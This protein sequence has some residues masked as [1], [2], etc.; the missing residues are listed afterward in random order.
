[1]ATVVETGLYDFDPY[2]KNVKNRIVNERH[3]LQTP[4]RDDYFFIIPRAAP[5]YVSSLKVYNDTTGALYKEGVDYLPGHYFV[6]AMQS[7]DKP[8]AGSIRFL[9]HSISG[10]VRLEY[11]TLGGQWG[12]NSNAI[13][14]EL[15]NKQLNPL[16]RSWGMI[17]ELPAS[18]PVVDHDQ[19]IDSIVGSE[20]LEEA[21]NSIADVLEAT[22]SGTNASHLQDFNN[23]HKVT[24]TQ[25][26]LSNV[27]NWATAT[28]Q[29]AIQGVANT[30][31]M[32]PYLTKRAIEAIALAPLND[33][34][35][36]TNNPHGVNA[37]DVGLGDVAN[38][39]PAS[40]DEAI[41]P[42]VN[43]RYLTPYT[44]SLLLQAQSGEA[45]YAALQELI[46]GHINNKENPHGVTAA[47]LGAYTRD[48][49]D[50]RL[51]NVSA[52]DTPLFAGMDP[53]QWR[54]TLPSFENLT[55][56]LDEIGAN[57]QNG[58][59]AIAVVDTDDPITQA[60][61][62]AKLDKV[63]ASL[64][65][66]T[67]SYAVV[68]V[69]GNTALIDPYA[70]TPAE[71]PLSGD[72]FAQQNERYY[73]IENDGIVTETANAG[74]IPAEYKPG[75][76]MASADPVTDLYSTA[77]ALYALTTEGSLVRFLNAAATVLYPSGIAGVYVNSEHFNAGE[78]ILIEHE[79]GTMTPYGNSQWVSQ[80]NAILPTITSP[81][82]DVAIGDDHLVLLLDNAS[83]QVYSII[84]SGGISINRIPT[85]A[86]PVTPTKV[87][88]A[89]KHY[90]ILGEDGDCTLHG[91]NDYGQCQLRGFP[92][93]DV[94]CGNGF[95]VVIDQNDHVMF[96]GETETNALLYK[97][98]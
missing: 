30:G 63:P 11:H 48:E 32:N 21:I 34:I 75:G 64:D 44:A 29:H 9:N 13:L 89:F 2:M 4:G 65:A 51:A 74:A 91:N 66:W 85:P 46:T 37:D 88:G 55:T 16:R 57:F 36:N 47:Q 52:Q 40:R 93:K 56:I 49:I 82:A 7:I 83:V 43:N 81:I 90:A 28:E 3:T 62:Q 17:A 86:L 87:H 98:A 38:Y 69:G 59:V 70:D 5:Y 19:S 78:M 26:G 73:W 50:Q 71:L 72:V 10:I 42:T 77:T 31:F 22:A 18:F 45:Q 95:T 27:P 67:C 35:N 61:K 76:A 92:L 15:S 60:M 23:P 25:V 8:V 97:T 14:A 84:R 68:N 39:P 53:E 94:A 6:E 96:F 41:D 20:E 1:M 12:F 54:Q 80:M 79:D 33:H 58:E 24:K